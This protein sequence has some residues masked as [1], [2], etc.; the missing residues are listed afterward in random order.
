MKRALF[1]LVGL[2]LALLGCSG[3]EATAEQVMDPDWLPVNDDYVIVFDE[4]GEGDGGAHIVPGAGFRSEKEEQE[5]CAEHWEND[6][7]CH[8]VALPSE[9]ELGQAQQPV[10]QHCW[11]GPGIKVNQVNIG[12]QNLYGGPCYERNSDGS[13]HDCA[14]PG[15]NVNTVLTWKYETAH[16]ND[17]CSVDRANHPR[18]LAGR[19]TIGDREYADAFEAWKTATGTAG[20]RANFQ[21]RSDTQG[22]MISVL[23]ADAD[24]QD[25]H[26][27][28]LGSGGPWGSL[29]VDG[30]V[31]KL[32]NADITQAR[33]GSNYRPGNP[34][35][36]LAYD[37]GV[38]WVYDRVIQR[39]VANCGGTTA[40]RR[41]KMR[42]LAYLLSLHEVGHILGFMHSQTGIM[43]AAASCG[44]LGNGNGTGARIAVP[45]VYADLYAAYILSRTN[46]LA[47]P[48]FADRQF[49]ARGPAPLAG[50]N[51]TSEFQQLVD[52]Q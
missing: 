20:G 19:Q 6:P 40:Q 34:H 29:R 35:S 21:Q 46:T 27:A 50:S 7:N 1:A 18:F 39:T 37:S 32:S 31:S 28:A 15:W 52:L 43:K 49:C 3:A 25:S 48:V 51:H 30:P 36:A 45:S 47:V 10:A 23:C 22:A 2:G 17:V 44:D 14:F 5:Y 13:E 33:L 16:N 38:F 9:G 41:E 26:A 11:T 8:Q 24:Y 42:T 12:N 4:I